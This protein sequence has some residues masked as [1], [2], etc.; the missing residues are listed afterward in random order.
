[1]DRSRADLSAHRNLWRWTR[2]QA[3]LRTETCSTLSIV[4][5]AGHRGV[6]ARNAMDL[7]A[8]KE[9]WNRFGRTDPMWAILS[10]PGK[11]KGQWTPEEFFDTG[12]REIA[13][14]LNYAK[15]LS[16][17]YRRRRALDFGCGVGRLTQALAPHFEE[18]H[19]VDI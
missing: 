7:S 1:M 15:T 9:H 13:Y 3:D 6:R 8:L 12:V 5:E 11:E 4:E 18:V 14:V 17:R 16:V 2:F 10:W 19:G